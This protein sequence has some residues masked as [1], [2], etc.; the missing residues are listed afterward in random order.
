MSEKQK[1]PQQCGFYRK[2]VESIYN[3]TCLLCQ[4]IELKDR[5]RE[6]N[7]QIN[8]NF[9]ILEQHGVSMTAGEILP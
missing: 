8:Q 7:I 5:S 2:L 4:E 1:I 6:V 9:E 3:T